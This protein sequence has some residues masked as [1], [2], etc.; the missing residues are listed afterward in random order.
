MIGKPGGSLSRT[1]DWNIEAL[2]NDSKGRYKVSCIHTLGDKINLND[3]DIFWFYAKS[4]HPKVYQ[5]IISALPNAKTIFGPNV[6]LDKPDIGPSDDWDDWYI[7]ECNPSIHLDQVSFY[8]EH[9][10]KFL[11]PNVKKVARHI[12]KCMK[13][14]DSL[15]KPNEEKIYDCLIYSK[16]RRYDYNFEDF[17]YDLLL[18][19]ENNNIKFCE[20]PAGKFGSYEREDYFNL[21]NKSKVTVNLSLDECPGILNY[22]SMFFNVPVIG[23]PHN[24]PITSCEELHVNNTDVMT[25]K[26]L[27][28]KND[29]AQKYFHKIKSFLNGKIASQVNHR[30]WVLKE[31]DFQNYCNRLSVIIK[32][33]L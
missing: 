8:S 24:V 32:E 30:D 12:N 3:F 15:Y 10:K 22:E 16:K 7:N 21:L 11:R 18:L 29:A 19:L 27:V 6:L 13:I 14:D 9:V 28:R 23:S 5:S 31:T 4:F 17:R 20:V 33:L 26:Y 1:Y 25:E 2:N